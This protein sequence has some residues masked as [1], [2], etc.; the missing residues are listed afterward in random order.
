MIHHL[1]LEVLVCP[2]E[3]YGTTGAVPLDVPSTLYSLFTKHEEGLESKIWKV[4]V[5]LL[6]VGDR[7]FLSWWKSHV[8]LSDESL[9]PV[10]AAD[11]LHV[12]HLEVPPISRRR[13]RALIQR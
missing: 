5:I 12:C 7:L 8:P 6:A 4:L 11:G 1:L 3:H 9:Q 2:Y 13:R 10:V